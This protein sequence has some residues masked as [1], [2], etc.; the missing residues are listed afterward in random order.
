MSSIVIANWFVDTWSKG[1]R[2]VSSI[3]FATAVITP[4]FSSRRQS[5]SPRGYFLYDIPKQPPTA[6]P[7]YDVY[8]IPRGIPHR[9]ISVWRPKCFHRGCHRHRRNGRMLRRRSSTIR[10]QVN[11]ACGASP[12]VAVNTPTLD[13]CL[14]YP[15]PPVCILIRTLALLPLSPVHFFFFFPN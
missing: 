12:V 8:H 2:C 14:I 13:P 3:F 1:S 6:S 5:L 7:W 10:R 4:L 9:V 15:S 11:I